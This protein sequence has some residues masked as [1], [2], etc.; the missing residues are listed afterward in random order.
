MA[1][2]LKIK[3]DNEGRAGEDEAHLGLVR[4]NQSGLPQLRNADAGK[5]R[6][7]ELVRIARANA[8]G[9]GVRI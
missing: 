4:R 2:T 5:I 7:T 6:P 8:F 9:H 1:E 3:T